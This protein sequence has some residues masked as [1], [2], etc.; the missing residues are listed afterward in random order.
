[1]SIP[2]GRPYVAHMDAAAAH[3]AG[4]FVG[5]GRRILAFTHPADIAAHVLSAQNGRATTTLPP[6]QPDAA[7][8]FAPA[9][10][11]RRPKQFRSLRL[12]GA[13][14][15]ALAKGRLAGLTALIPPAC[16]PY[17]ARRNMWLRLG[18]GSSAPP[19][20]NGP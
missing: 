14:A 13:A 3:G 16:R 20:I 7:L 8:I 17:A 1:P 6:E 12:S 10:R 5:R 11:I 9:D 19:G 15:I 18:P 4:F 2:T